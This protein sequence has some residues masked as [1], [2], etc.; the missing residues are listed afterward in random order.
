MA[1][2]AWS[3]D[4]APAANAD[5]TAGW[6]SRASANR[7]TSWARPDEI[8]ACQVNQW[9]SDLTPHPAHDPVANASAASSTSWALSTLS[10]PHTSRS[11]TSMS[12]SA[13]VPGSSSTTTPI[14]HTIHAFADRMQHQFERFLPAARRPS[15][16]DA[17]RGCD[18]RRHWSVARDRQGDRRCRRGAG[19]QL[20]LVARSADALAAV[21]DELG[22]RPVI[23]AADLADGRQVEH[24]YEVARRRLG[25]VDILVN[26]SRVGCW[27]PFVEID[28]AAAKR[29]EAVNLDAALQLTRLVLPEMIRRRRGHIVNVRSVAGR[30]GVPFEAVYSA[31]S[32]AVAARSLG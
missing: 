5:I 15:S 32:G 23:V 8:P 4:N 7:T 9:L 6:V 20:G 2:A 31:T 10:C 19:A 22:G 21:R 28:E 25:P 17:L 16:T 24:A 1:I 11:R 29:V 26:S 3:T 27:G 13:P 18:R 14:P 12:T 30:L